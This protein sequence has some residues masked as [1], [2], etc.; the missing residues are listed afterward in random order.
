MSWTQEK[1]QTCLSRILCYNILEMPGKVAGDDEA[2]LSRCFR[3]QE[4]PGDM[5]GTAVF[6]ASGESAFITGQTISE[7]GGEVKR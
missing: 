4:Y 6:L 7:D 1:A 2:I 3:R 5:V